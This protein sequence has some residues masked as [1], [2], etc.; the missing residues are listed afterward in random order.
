MLCY[1]IA[2]G[3]GALT[4]TDV[5]E[6]VLQE[7]EDDTLQQL[8]EARDNLRLGEVRLPQME[9]EIAEAKREIRAHSAATYCL[10]VGCATCSEEVQMP[11]HGE[12][13]EGR[14]PQTIQV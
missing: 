13:G 7:N 8:E 14:A 12:K 6:Q 3:V 5:I 9:E 4:S 10:T 1:L 2:P 11:L